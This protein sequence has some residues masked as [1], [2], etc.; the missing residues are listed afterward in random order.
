[1]IK[2]IFSFSVLILMV[3]C[4]QNGSTTLEEN[5]Y[6]NESTGWRIELPKGWETVSKKENSAEK[7]IGKKALEQVFEGD[8][9]SEYEVLLSIKNNRNASLTSTL[10][11]FDEQY[12]GEWKDNNVFLKE[13]L[14]KAFAKQNILI[15]T[16]SSSDSIDNM[17]FEVFYISLYAPNKT[18][19]LNQIL[20]SSL[21]NG[22]DFGVTI[23]Y[24]HTE[25]KEILLKALKNSQF[26]S[27][28]P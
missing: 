12:E 13:L 19:I 17:P 27:I 2:Y 15:D 25:D 14:Y 9:N 4:S 1:M 5:I 24:V 6:Y 16:T 10:E 28:Q 7:Q 3:A 8:I 18:V 22:Y 21:I 11:K 26:K 20:Y 23:N